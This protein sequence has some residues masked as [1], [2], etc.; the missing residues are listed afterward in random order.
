VEWLRAEG[1]PFEVECGTVLGMFL[2]EGGTTI[3]CDGTSY[4]SSYRLRR[5]CARDSKQPSSGL[6]DLHFGGF[7]HSYKVDQD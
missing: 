6:Y 7:A 3:Q 5:A 2:L 4:R 1:V